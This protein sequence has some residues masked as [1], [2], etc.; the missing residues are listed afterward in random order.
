MFLVR[1]P[2]FTTKHLGER[3]PR[4]GVN[5]WS[6]WCR[7]KGMELFMD[8][9]ALDILDANDAGDEEDTP[10][11]VSIEELMIGKPKAP[12]QTLAETIGWNPP[13]VGVSGSN[14]Q[15]QIV[16]TGNDGQQLD[17]SSLFGGAGTTTFTINGGGLQINNGQLIIGDNTQVEVVGNTNAN[18]NNNNQA[19]PQVVP[20]SQLMGQGA[21]WSVVSLNQNGNA[22]NNALNTNNLA[23]LLRMNARKDKPKA[24]P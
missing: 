3:H 14:V 15:Q 9:S 17:L 21:T 4:Q 1:V 23:Q 6:N 19:I 12:K 24:K 5:S 10:R 22:M 11:I 2:S 18:G 8:S 13:N 7:I 16:F 20:F